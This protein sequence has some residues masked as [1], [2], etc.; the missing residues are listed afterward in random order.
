MAE[1][2]ELKKLMQINYK[3]SD[4]NF[5]R[6]F[7]LATEETYGDRE[8]IVEEGTFN[9]NIYIVKEGLLRGFHYLNG[10]KEN[11]LYFAVDGDILMSM[12]CFQKG[13]PSFVRI[14]AFSKSTVYKVPKQVM[15]DLARES[16]E[17]ANWML[18]MTL[19]ELFILERKR[20]LLAGDALERYNILVKSRP[21]LLQKVPL[22]VIASYLGIAQASLSR[23]RSPRY[24][25]ERD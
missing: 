6:L 23:L 7:S 15:L 22:K 19:E 20:K 16:I 12:H 3:L 9:D 18:D 4:E 5:D 25:E 14:E 13:L 24:K 21:E 8:A 10:G 1:N 17:F 11:T 2:S